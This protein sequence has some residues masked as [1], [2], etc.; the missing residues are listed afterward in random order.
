TARSRV[1]ARR[2][3]ARPLRNGVGSPRMRV[4]LAINNTPAY[5]PRAINTDGSVY[6]PTHIFAASNSTHFRTHSTLSAKAVSRKKHQA[7]QPAWNVRAQ[8]TNNHTPRAGPVRAFNAR[9]TGVAA[10]SLWTTRNTPCN[11]PQTRNDQLAPCHRPPRS[12]VIIRFTL[13]RT[14]PWRSP[15]GGRGKE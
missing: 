7:R 5:D 15:P 12:M 11:P 14:T 1:A 13:V 6:V 10:H 2:P 4:A 8:A 3:Q 9:A